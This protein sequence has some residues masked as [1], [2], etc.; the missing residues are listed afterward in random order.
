[1]KTVTLPDCIISL[2]FLGESLGPALKLRTKGNITIP[3]SMYPFN[4]YV[5]V[6]A[7]YQTT[8]L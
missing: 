8:E 2:P 5:L 3:P 7:M 1:M 6:P 4:K